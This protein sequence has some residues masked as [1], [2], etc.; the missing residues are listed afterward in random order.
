MYKDTL[1]NSKIPTF[2]YDSLA[3]VVETKQD[4]GQKFKEAAP[5]HRA[6][7]DEL[8][9]WSSGFFLFI[10]HYDQ[11]LQPCW[12]SYFLIYEIER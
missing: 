9:F 4:N 2:S 7:N 1:Y 10:I 3:D 5:W 6:K 11:V 12:A 8:C